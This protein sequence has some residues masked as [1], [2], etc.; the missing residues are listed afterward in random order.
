MAPTLQ[1]IGFKKSGKTLVIESMVKQ[2]VEQN[3]AVSVLKHDAHNAAMDKNGTDSDRFFKAGAMTVTLKS[4]TNYFTHKRTTPDATIAE[5]VAELPDQ[6]QI[7]LAEGFKN[8]HFDK[9]ALLRPT[10]HKADLASFT[11]IIKYASLLPH[12]G[13]DLVG[14]NAIMNW[15]TTDYLERRDLK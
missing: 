6:P 4:D 13:V 12:S 5:L 8:D 7:V 10:D 3:I 9:L 1:V 15:F 14:L 11:H 2:L